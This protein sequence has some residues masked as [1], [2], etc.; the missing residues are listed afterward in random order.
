M[1]T[2]RLPILHSTDI[3]KLRDMATDDG[4]PN[5]VSNIALWIIARSPYFKS[6]GYEFTKEELN[7]LTD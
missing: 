5:L 7:K 2:K 6:K 4:Q 1:A 3:K